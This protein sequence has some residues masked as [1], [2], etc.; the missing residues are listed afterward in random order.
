MSAHCHPKSPLEAL[1]IITTRFQNIKKL[2]QI[3]AT[4]PV[5]TCTAE[6]SISSLKLLK[7]FLRNRMTDDRLN[8]LALLY[9]HFGDIS[10]DTYD[11]VDYFINSSTRRTNFSI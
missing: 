8:G 7:A 9:I 3:F 10:V 6:R 5:T 4:V 2:L 1:D 11:V